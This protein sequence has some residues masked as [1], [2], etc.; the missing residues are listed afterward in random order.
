MSAWSPKEP[1]RAPLICSRPAS[2]RS[3]ADNLSQHA[4][5]VFRP[6][7]KCRRGRDGAHQPY[8]DAF[9][10]LSPIAAR[11]EHLLREPLNNLAAIMQSVPQPLLRRDEVPGR[12]HAEPVN[13]AGLQAID[14][15]GWRQHDETKILSRVEAARSHPKSQLVGMAR[16][17]KSAAK[18]KRRAPVA[19][20]PRRDAREAPLQWRAGAAPRLQAPP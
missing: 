2:I 13:V 19:F 18:C 8:Q 20:S 5:P 15:V 17:R 11:R 4:L 9:I 7:R 10:V 14:H 6:A 1:L 12:A 3:G 16:K